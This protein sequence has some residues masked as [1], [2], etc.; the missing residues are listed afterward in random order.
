MANEHSI[1]VNASGE[2]GQLERGLKN[3]KKD[4]S[5]VL[6]EIDKG[7]R[8]G[9]LFDDTQL[10]ALDVFRGR[11]KESMDEMNR[12][13]EKQNNLVDDL[14]RKKEKAS[15]SEREDID[16]EIRAR[17]KA[18]DAI[19]RQLRATEDLYKRRDAEARDY[20][21]IP[22]TSG[23]AQAP[24]SGGGGAGVG[25]GLVGMGMSKML[26][27]GKFIAGLAGIA[28]IA[29]MASEAYQL[30][31]QS[32]IMP[33]D[34]SQRIR[35]DGYVGSAKNMWDEIGDIGRND[36]MGYTSAESW[37]FQDQYSR[38]A[39]ALSPQELEHSMKF[40]RGYGLEVNETTAALS[41][42]RELGGATKVSE[43][44][45][46][47]AA[48]VE[49]SGMTPRI[50]EVMQTSAG[51][52][53][54]MNTTLKDTGAKQILAYQ[55]TLD[56]IGQEKGMIS[57]TGQ[58]GA[59]L[60][61]GLGG[62]YSPE[63]GNQWKWMG[64]QALQ[65]HDPKK[66]GNMGLFD[67]EQSF[68][69][70]LMN[71]DNLPAMAGYIKQGSGG[72]VNIEKR[73]LQK[74]LQDGGYNATKRQTSELYEATNGL[75]AF[76]ADKMEALMD[77]LM[78]GDG[79]AKYQERIG[80][81]GQ[82]ILDVNSRFEK[83][84]ENLG[85]PILEI[86]TGI[87]EG[88]TSLMEEM[89]N[90]GN[91][92]TDLLEEI[93]DFLEDNWGLLATAAGIAG[94]A[95]LLSKLVPSGGNGNKPDK[96]SDKDNKPDKNNNTP[97]K[98]NNNTPGSNNSNNNKKPPI[99]PV[100]GLGALST[101]G[102]LVAFGSTAF[103]AFNTFESGDKEKHEKLMEKHGYSEEEIAE[104]SGFWDRFSANFFSGLT[105]GALSVEDQYAM[106][107]GEKGEEFEDNF[108]GFF[109]NLGKKL[110][111]SSN[112]PYTKEQQELSDKQYEINKKKA[113][114]RQEHGWFKATF[115]DSWGAEFTLMKEGFFKIVNDAFG[116]DWGGEKRDAA[117]DKLIEMSDGGLV[118]LSGMSEHGIE[119]LEKL[120]AQGLLKLETFQTSGYT[121]INGMSVDGKAELQKMAEQG[122]ISIHGLQADGTTAVTALSEDG[123]AR[124]QEL[125]EKGD[126]TFDEWYTGTTATLSGF[127]EDGKAKLVK[128]Q[129]QGLISIGGFSE[130]GTA[131]ITAL[132]EQGRE[133][134]ETLKAD[135]SI[136]I[137]KF[138]EDGRLKI[139]DLSEKGAEELLKLQKN[140]SLSMVGMDK[141]TEEELENI[142]EINK[143]KMDSIEAE[144]K[145]WSDR[146]V[147]TDGIFTKWADGFGSLWDG[148]V[149]ALKS[150]LPSWL[151]GGGDSSVG[152]GGNYEGKYADIIN[153]N[154]NKHGIDPLLVASLIK[155]ESGFDT[156]ALSHAGAMGLMQLM[157]GTARGLGVNNA[158]DPEQNVAGG[159]QYLADLIK[160]YNG[161]I[162][163]ALT[164]YNW[165]SGNMDSYLKS[166]R[167]VNG[168][169]RPKESLEYAQRVM[170]H[171]EKMMREQGSANGGFFNGWEKRITSGYGNQENF[172]SHVHRGLDI[173]GE[174]GDPLQALAGGKIAF[175]HMDDGGK[176][177]VDGKKNTRSGG[178]EIGIEMPNGETYFYSHL[179]QIN[180]QIADAWFGGNKDIN[181]GAG[182]YLGNVGG[183]RGEAGSGYSTTGSHLHLGYMD[184]NGNLRDPMSLMNRIFGGAGDSDIGMMAAGGMGDSAL[185]KSLDFTKRS[186]GDVFRSL[187]GES[188]IEGPK[189]FA[190]GA[191]H[192]HQHEGNEEHH[193]QHEGN[194]EHRH[195]H[196]HEG[197][198]EHQ[199]YHQYEGFEGLLPMGNLLV[200]SLDALTRKLGEVVG[201]LTDTSPDAPK[202]EQEAAQ[203]G[204]WDEKTDLIESRL[205]EFI[206]RRVPGIP[207]DPP[208]KPAD[209]GTPAEH[210]YDSLAQR[211]QFD[212]NSRSLAEAFGSMQVVPDALDTG[213]A[214]RDTAPG[215]TSTL[216]VN[217]KIEG[218]GAKELNNMTLTQL[219]NF[220]SQI[221]SEKEAHR[222]S[223]NPTTGGW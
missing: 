102:S 190:G 76:D 13:F 85:Q 194:E 90:S 37:A 122:L 169:A 129:E 209:M 91:G 80:Q 160:K 17:E 87:K 63:Q 188:T 152:I 165:G 163:H 47:V 176:Y 173:N 79:T 193:H 32:Q 216:N 67:L 15:R 206:R 153:E 166:G 82:D 50:L 43:F 154:A 198:E 182:Q 179:A 19:R 78:K 35:G 124:L 48:S 116:T 110:F 218:S 49:R 115:P 4:L 98:N 58:K 11:F 26:G 170:A 21:V 40:G 28:G 56:V 187:L 183:D 203:A 128:L 12:E 51:L 120:A 52:L 151:G 138:S 71:P 143:E 65:K 34:L 186:L 95:T 202:E 57:L 174:Q 108:T 192:H 99:I 112:I 88:F 81:L 1:R 161:N 36:Q 141:T 139:S 171:Y 205:R 27:A 220:V 101:L 172:R 70:G 31:Q 5:G 66:Y 162:E 96:D 184:K 39:G 130:D 196:Q 168:Q 134:L 7:A 74:W 155:Q 9:G 83:Q 119:K 212:A 178:S 156:H 201:W 132:S 55:T 217:V 144:H 97:D 84:L 148:L 207:L 133:E 150:T 44:S 10:R 29:S 222:L 191:E 16:K 219:R 118:T 121:A 46:M 158:F 86:V 195:Y 117:H 146:L 25:G 24:S 113:E 61:G 149:E 164:A 94:L 64:L 41:S 126:L 107:H 213:T 3:L 23:G 131:K 147:G 109:E 221:L 200:T 211:M 223:T 75:T 140:G 53:A 14:H 8:S 33:M 175:I 185:S 100:A 123:K 103:G 30:A 177:D 104:N 137:S 157:P 18:M 20:S 181:I 89:T 208:E 114:E 68:E 167:G 6:G 136:E 73:M 189:P 45:N 93:R 69:D 210:G 135:G 92:I 127:S 22:G 72:D 2:F 42:V 62:I 54:S 214:Q 59:D 180:K 60:I 105:F 215:T 106:S 199:H 38:Q 197:N 204:W 145:S 142:R 125:K 111:P 77:D 159:T